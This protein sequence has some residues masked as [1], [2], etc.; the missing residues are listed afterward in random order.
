MFTVLLHGLFCWF[1][2]HFDSICFPALLTTIPSFKIFHILLVFLFFKS[3]N[4][5][6]YNM[7]MISYRSL[8]SVTMISK[9]FKE[10]LKQF[11]CF[12][13]YFNMSIILELL[14]TLNDEDWMKV[15]TYFFPSIL[16]KTDRLQGK[17]SQS[18]IPLRL[19]FSERGASITFS[20]MI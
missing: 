17:K 14:N 12:V 2:F 10:L 15:L 20:R 13:S 18:K 1:F 9:E 4:S 8:Y 16:R 3:Q 7:I 5:P 11:F 6:T 19:L